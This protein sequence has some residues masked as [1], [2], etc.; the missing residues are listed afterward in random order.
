[1]RNIEKKITLNGQVIS[2]RGIEKDS[3]WSDFYYFVLVSSWRRILL[4][5]ACVYLVI[6]VI[7]ASLYLLGGDCIDH[8]AVGSFW[9]SFFFSIQTWATIGYGAMAPKTR[10]ADVLVAI[11]SF[12]GLL[13]MSIITGLVFSKFAQPK[14]KVRF[15]KNV[16]ITTHDSKPVLM[17]R[18]GN[19]RGNQIVEARLMVVWSTEHR[20]SEGV[21]FRK[22]L[23]LTLVRATTVMFSLSWTAMHII[24]ENSPLYKI[25]AEGLQNL[26]AEIIVSLTGLDAEFNQTVHARQNYR[27]QDFVYGHRFADVLSRD[28]SGM[29]VVDYRDFDSLVPSPRS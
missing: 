12:F 20:T 28:Q 8:A 18:M 2:I 25:T 11:E 3:F 24:D 6:N 26:K 10:Y 5:L 13:S 4:L 16:L 19:L 7:F 29:R 14:A 9:D 15:T 1:M 22:L 23:D 17:F 21:E 27:A